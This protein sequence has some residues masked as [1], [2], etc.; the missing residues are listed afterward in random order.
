LIEVG[1]RVRDL[2][3]AKELTRRGER[4][5]D[6]FLTALARHVTTGFGGKVSIAPRIF[7]RELV[8]VLDK[9]DQYGE[10]DPAAQYKLTLEDADLGDEELAARHGLAAPPSV[11]DVDATTGEDGPTPPRRL[12]G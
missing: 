11:A 3:P 5:G 12:D 2:Y 6:A 9:V 1:R 8:D 4:A 7:L 10:Y